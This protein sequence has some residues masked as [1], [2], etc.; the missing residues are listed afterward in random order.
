MTFVSD[1]SEI[2]ELLKALGELFWEDESTYVS[3]FSE[4]E[5]GAEFQADTY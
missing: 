5:V 1:R 4:W 3:S 2:C